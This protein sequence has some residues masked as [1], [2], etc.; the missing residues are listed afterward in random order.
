M[1]ERQYDVALS[2]AGEDRQHAERLAE[3]LTADGYSVFWTYSGEVSKV[4]SFGFG[5]PLKTF[6]Y[7]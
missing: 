7:S 6:R 3:L 2:F 1:K 4:C 5:S